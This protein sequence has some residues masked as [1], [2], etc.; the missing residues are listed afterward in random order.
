MSVTP[1]TLCH[2][3]WQ[4]AMQP[5][6]EA[7]RTICAGMRWNYSREHCP[8]PV[9]AYTKRIEDRM[10]QTG[11]YFCALSAACAVIVGCSDSAADITPSGKEETAKTQLLEA[12][13]ALL[14]TSAPLGPMNVYLVGF[15]PLKDKPTH[16]MEAHHFCNQV[17]EDFAQCVLFDGNTAE[18]N[19]NG[20][21][22]IIS[23]RLFASLPEQERA[24]WHPH[25]Y[26]ILSGQLAAPNLPDVAEM[27][28][29]KSKMNSYGKTWHVWNTGAAG[30]AG[31]KLPL[32]V[33]RLAWSFNHDGEAQPGLV[34]QRDRRLDLDSVQTRRERAALAG[35][36]HPQ[37]GVDALRDEFPALRRHGV[38]NG[39]E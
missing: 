37:S 38:T 11:S 24:F 33:A 13:A 36:A 30:H 5:T 8:G 29:M 31:D 20:I 21:E 35:L 18:A 34:E 32:G 26:E 19:L 12:G 10:M 2:L 16:Q 9:P 7:S 17:N 1:Y 14:Q 6:A 4:E 22:Y 3:P 15:H 28:L 27:E 39:N 25:N 23:E